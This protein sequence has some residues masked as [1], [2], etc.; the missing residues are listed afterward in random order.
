MAPELEK[1]A[2]TN[3][4]RVLVGKVDTEVVASLAQQYQI[5]ALPTLVLF[6]RGREI[7]RV[8]G[9][10]SAREIQRFVDQAR[11]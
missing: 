3:A 10:R 5:T 7:G 6:S 9:A 11:G 4:G 2:A 1:V 8:Q